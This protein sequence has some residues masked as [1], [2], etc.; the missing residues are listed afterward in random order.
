MALAEI[1]DKTQVATVALAARYTPLAAVVAGTTLGRLLA[2]VPV[3]LLGDRLLKRMPV[4]AIHEVAAGLFLLL[5]V[6]V[7][8][9]F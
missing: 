6:G 9:G 4:R 2:N 3:V 5:D 8:V 1:G 7:L